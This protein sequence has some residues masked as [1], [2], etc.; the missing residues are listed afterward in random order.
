M[1]EMV[2]GAVISAVT[3]HAI[4]LA[5]AEFTNTKAVAAVTPVAA[6]PPDPLQVSP[7]PGGPA[8]GIFGRRRIGGRVVLSYSSGTKT[9][10]AIVLAS[11]P[12]SKILAVH[13]NNYP[14]ALQSN[15]NVASSPWSAG[16]TTSALNVRVYDG[17]QTTADATLVA[18]V[19]GFTADF[20]GKKTAYLAIT[21]DTGAFPAAAALFASGQPDFTAD[22]LGFKC[23]DPRDVTQVLATPSTWKWS[24][25]ASI[26]DANYLIHELGAKVP[27]ARVDWASVA[28]CATIDDQAVTLKNGTKEPRYECSAYWHCDERHED[29]RSRIEATHA[30]GLRLIGNKWVCTTGVWVAPVAAITSDDYAGGGGLQYTEGVAI[31]ASCNG[32]RGRYT[33]PA[34]DYET[35]DFPPYQDATAL[36]EDG[37]EIWLDFD[38]SFV[39][40]HTQ[41]QRLGRIAFKRARFGYPAT[42]ITGLHKMKVTSVDAVTLTD[43]FAGLAA[44]SFRVTNAK[45]TLNSEGDDAFT[46]RFSLRAEDATTFAWNPAT[47]ELT[48]NS[49]IA[50]R[51]TTSYAANYAFVSD[52]ETA[53]VGTT[54][55]IIQV[56]GPFPVGVNVVRFWRPDGTETV[57]TP[58]TA[59]ESVNLT[60]T[61]FA[62]A[63]GTFGYRIENSTTGQ[64]SEVVNVTFTTAGIAQQP[65]SSLP[66]LTSGRFRFPQPAAP[67][68][69]A[70]SISVTAVTTSVPSVTPALS[71][72]IIWHDTPSYADAAA[73][74][75]GGAGNFQ[76]VT[77]TTQTVAVTG[78]AGTTKYYWV[79]SVPGATPSAWD[80]AGAG[81]VSPASLPAGPARITF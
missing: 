37:T 45:L 6:P 40:S 78:T 43:T 11:A 71:L 26:I 30:G 48:E 56:V 16:P 23:Y 15:G 81:G 69:G 12:L 64:A 59:F 5:A 32:V 74:V 34:H 7:E 41:A 22:V 66:G 51:F 39:T 29:V 79:R 1:A 53:T 21:I 25:N 49:T 47:D 20:I 36:A 63:T 55:P 68:A 80:T 19:P 52:S 33:S 3:G 13:I 14:V 27:T 44:A 75:L 10:L 42:V 60:S 18:N 58:G 57:K 65:Q 4:G 9:H 28:T 38:A 67:V 77:N 76:V 50:G 24:G 54:V 72:A 46:V 62:P 70:S 31:E 61:H 73:A 35:R 8:I 2:I 17:T